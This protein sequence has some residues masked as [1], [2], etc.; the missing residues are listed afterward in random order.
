M[1][2]LQLTA[3]VL[4]GLTFMLLVFLGS[5]MAN[6]RKNAARRAQGHDPHQN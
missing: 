6:N 3:V 1:S 2:A 5:I 4:I